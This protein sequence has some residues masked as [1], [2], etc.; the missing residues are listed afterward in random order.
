MVTYG[1]GYQYKYQKKLGIWADGRRAACACEFH[2][3]G[4]PHAQLPEANSRDVIS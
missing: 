2:A 1:R 3:D 4:Q